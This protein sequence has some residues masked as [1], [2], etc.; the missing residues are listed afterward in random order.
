MS[1]DL[2]PMPVVDDT[3]IATTTQ[4]TV[5]SAASL[6]VTDDTSYVQ[7]GEH[8]TGLRALSKEIEAFFKEPTEA[9]HKTWKALTSKRKGLIDPIEA[10]V[11]RL[12]KQMAAYAAEQARKAR[13][14]AEQAAREAQAREQAAALAEAA[15]LEAAG[16]GD[17]ALAAMD[18]LLAPMPLIAATPEVVVPKVAGISYRETWKHR[19]VDASLIPRE[20]LM[21]NESSIATVIAATKGAVKIPGVEAVVERG[22]VVR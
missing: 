19:I 4:V 5:G 14:A 8:V 2:L 6:T 22:T 16:L 17:D 13:E 21:P 7:A 18:A 1:T 15:G 3:T 10:Q 20:Y 12:G 11:S 9:A